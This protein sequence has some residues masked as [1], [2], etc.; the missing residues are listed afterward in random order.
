M[1]FIKQ[2]TERGAFAIHRMQ[3]VA[4]AKSGLTPSEY[5]AVQSE[6][7]DEFDAYMQV[8]FTDTNSGTTRR[9]KT[10]GFYTGGTPL[11]F[12]VF[13][14]DI[15]GNVTQFGMT[16]GRTDIDATAADDGTNLSY[17]FWTPARG[18][19]MRND[20]QKN[21]T[22]KAMIKTIVSG[23][24][25]DNQR[26]SDIVD[27]TAGLVA[28]LADVNLSQFD[29]GGALSQDPEVTCAGS[30]KYLEI[31]L[32]T[33]NS[34]AGLA[35]NKT[36]GVLGKEIN[37]A[38]ANFL[39]G[40]ASGTGSVNQ[41]HF[42]ELEFEPALA[43]VEIQ[44]GSA[45]GAMAMKWNNFASNACDVDV[46]PGIHNNAL[47][48]AW[49][50]SNIALKGTSATC[51]HYVSLNTFHIFGA[52]FNGTLFKY[53]VEAPGEGSGGTPLRKVQSWGAVS[54]SAHNSHLFLGFS[55]SA[56]WQPKLTVTN[57]KAASAANTSGYVRMHE[58]TYVSSIDPTPEFQ[59]AHYLESGAITISGTPLS[60]NAP[61]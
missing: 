53:F 32:A 34:S 13:Q 29:P 19:K 44:Y 4:T 22:V 38:D 51:R 23:Y 27:C 18:D 6:L 28:D 45:L 20:L 12:S 14:T 52:E 36:A 56:K 16:M 8:N 35:G 59:R 9:D 61:A 24:V 2:Q 50:K 3:M 43:D 26:S 54:G 41:L 46:I 39:I 7:S 5:T 17:R 11:N 48:G 60:T 47:R 10:N 30:P 33:L 15:S 37:V 21:S 31:D 40:D 49:D 25:Y 42:V 57:I 55:S 1:A 58:W